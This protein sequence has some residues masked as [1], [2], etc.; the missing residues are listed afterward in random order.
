MY[1]ADC[2]ARSGILGVI[3]PVAQTAT[4]LQFP[5]VNPLPCQEEHYAATS[6]QMLE[7]KGVLYY[8]RIALKLTL[9][10]PE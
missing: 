5:K 3:K 9:R 8:V 2:A 4:C 7:T 1:E 6:V 10:F